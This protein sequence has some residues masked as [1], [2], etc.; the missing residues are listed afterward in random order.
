MAA[1]H[2]RR[3]R[4]RRSP[5]P[6]PV[7]A[8]GLIPHRR[9]TRPTAATS[10][11]QHLLFEAVV[12][13]LAHAAR[14]R[15]SSS[16]STTCTGSIPRAASCSATSPNLGR[17]PILLVVA[18]R[19]EDAAADRELIA[20]LARLAERRIALT[21]LAEDPTAE[22]AAILLGPDASPPTF[23]RIAR[24]ADGNPLFVEELVAAVGTTGVPQTVRDLMLVRFIALDD[25]ARHLV[26]IAAVIGATAPPRGSSARR[27]TRRRTTPGLRRARRSTAARW[28]RATT[29]DYEFR[30][31]LLRQ[32]VLDELVPDERVA[33]HREIAEA[34]T[35]HP[36]SQ[37][38][39]TE[40]PSWPATGTRPSEADPALRWL[41]AAAQQAEE[42]Y[43]FEA[44]A[45]STS[46]HCS[47]GTAVADAPTVATVDHAALLLEAA[48]AE[49][50]AGHIERAADLA[51]T[52]LVE[53][54]A[55]DPS[56]G[57]EAAGRVYPVMWTA[58][59]ADDLFEFGTTSLL[60]V[61]DRVDPRRRPASS[62]A[63][64]IISS[65]RRAPA[66]S[67]NRRLT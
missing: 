44:A 40:S 5:A 25:D 54:F 36:E 23:E 1:E 3:R 41:V 45:D 11:G 38:E 39:S 20:Q 15:G 47:G 35:D 18:Y 66:R 34:L 28:S 24:D 30:H 65:R 57:V 9:W 51:W 49:G 16:W 58:D 29:A 37:S 63:G 7:R 4:G 6:R 26:R 13:L 53:S 61:L 50:A 14:A 2:R 12:E 59:R 46:G 52:G 42:A 21:R 33:F 10:G 60:P 62:S 22:M 48:D 43:A 31:A 32:A 55:L 8:R 19:A 67:A 56:R 27:R 64:S 17:V